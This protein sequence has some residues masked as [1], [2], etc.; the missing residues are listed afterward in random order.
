[1][2]QLALEELRWE[3]GRLFLRLSATLRDKSG[4]Q[5]RILE[6]DGMP[7]LLAEGLIP[8][9]AAQT[10]ASAHPRVAWED[11]GRLEITVRHRVTGVEWPVRSRF[12]LSRPG[13]DGGP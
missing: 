5:V 9:M 1:M 4:Q 11:L 10:G 13:A 7:E 2:H 6:R 12:E 3:G 8:A